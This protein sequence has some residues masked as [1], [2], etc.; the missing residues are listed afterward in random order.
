MPLIGKLVTN[1]ADSYRYLAESIRMHPDQET[2][3]SMMQE[4]GFTECDFYNMTG[5]VV[6]L[7]RGVKP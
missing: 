5:G 4:A 1:D 7:H 6:A 2:L 3:K